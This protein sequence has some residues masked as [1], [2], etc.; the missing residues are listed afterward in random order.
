MFAKTFLSI[1]ALALCGPVL[2]QKP[3]PVRCPAHLTHMHMDRGDYSS[4]PGAVFELSGFDAD[5][6]ARGKASPLCFVRT[7]EIKAGEVFVSSESLT[8]MFARKLSQSDSKLRDLKVETRDDGTAKLSGTMKK[9]LDVP[10]EIDG[11]VSTDGRNL[12]LQ[13]KNIKAGK[14]PIKW[15]LGMMGQNLGKMLQSQNPAGVKANGDTL[16]F[17]PA[18]IAHVEGHISKLQLTNKGLLLTF[19]QV[20]QSAKLKNTRSTPTNRSNWLH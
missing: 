15:L 3:D 7:T 17:Q 13:A 14:L 18:E 10:F 5:M 11:P 6:V 8:H 1:A 19:G 4:Q 20:Q 9:K 16:I 12:I 2:A